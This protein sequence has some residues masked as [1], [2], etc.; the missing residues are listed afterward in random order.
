MKKIIAI[1]SL[2][3]MFSLMGCYVSDAPPQDARAAHSPAAYGEGEYD[4]EAD[5]KGGD[6]P[7]P[8]PGT[9]ESETDGPVDPGPSW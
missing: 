2:F 3:L 7:P 8:A 4:Q 5:G 6:V 1:S 9:S